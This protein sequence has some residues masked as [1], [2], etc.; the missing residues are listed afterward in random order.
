MPSALEEVV[1]AGGA[2]AWAKLGDRPLCD[3][4]VGR[5]VG[6]AGHGLTNPARGQAVRERNRIR[7]DGPCWLCGGLLAEVPKL[8]ILA[9]AK[10]EP[11]DFHTFLIGSKVDPEVV[12]REESLWAELGAEHAEAIKSELNPEIGKLVEQRFHRPAEFRHPEIVA[13]DEPG[14]HTIDVPDTPPFV[15]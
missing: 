4:C 9:A 15:R 5:L 6:K 3:A 1:Q 2:L 8:A 13:I 7:G 14:F 12:A 11:W 10:L